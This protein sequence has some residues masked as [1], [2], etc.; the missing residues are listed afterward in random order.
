MKTNQIFVLFFCFIFRLSETAN[1]DKDES[2]P[3]EGCP[4]KLDHELQ[5][6]GQED[7]EL[8]KIVKENLLIPPPEI[9]GL[10]MLNATSDLWSIPKLRAQYGQPIA[11]Q[12]LFYGEIIQN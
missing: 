9:K 2:C 6:F 5:N 11:I 4:T 10:L 8:A 12:D 1:S 7:P 3:K